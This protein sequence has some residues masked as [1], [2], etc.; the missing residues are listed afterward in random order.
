MVFRNA[1]YCFDRKEEK[2]HGD[3][4][5]Y[6]GRDMKD[7]KV[8]IVDDVLTSGGSLLS[9]K[10]FVEAL[11]GEVLGAIVLI[12]R[13]EIADTDG[14]NNITAREVVEK[15]MGIPVL[16]VISVEAIANCL[17]SDQLH[18]EECEEMLD[19]IGRRKNV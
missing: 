19:K 11:G 12:D 3:V 5:K 18:V 7:M 14:E 6:V 16:S 4:G 1:Y 2:D 17:I 8:I 9:A 13:M 15:Q 10:E